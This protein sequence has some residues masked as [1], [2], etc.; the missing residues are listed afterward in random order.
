MVAVVAYQ[1]ALARDAIH[2]LRP[3]LGVPAEDEERSGDTF[4]A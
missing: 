2:Q 4:T 3:S 1:V